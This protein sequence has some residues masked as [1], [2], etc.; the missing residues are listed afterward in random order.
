[1]SSSH[2]GHV[3]SII[4]PYL[5]HAIAHSEHNSHD[6]RS[7]AEHTLTHIRALYR[8]RSTSDTQAVSYAE[9]HQRP[10]RSIV[11]DHILNNLAQSQD[12]DQATRDSAQRT[13]QHSQALRGDRQPDT[14]LFKHA[15]K[16]DLHRE[17]HNG[18]HSD[19]ND[20]LPGANILTEG[21]SIG[22]GSEEAINDCY[23]NLG[24][25]FDFYSKVL[26]RN[27]IDNRGLPLIGT[28]HF[29][30]DYGNAFWNSKRMVFGD[31]NTFIYNFTKALDVIGHE[32]THGVTENTAGLNYHNQ[33]GAL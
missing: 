30:K 10:H 28:I 24:R 14:T 12:V 8:T 21:Q 2:S 16:S 6:I 19:D 31:G 18:N 33:S 20:L 17:I 23:D 32:L 29:G 1:M 4:P 5:S 27:S 11:P 7:A 26:K 22:Q 9:H 13:L 25:T 15:H 3:C